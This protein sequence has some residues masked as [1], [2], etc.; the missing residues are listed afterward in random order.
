MEDHKMRMMKDGV[1]F[2]ELEELAAKVNFPLNSDD[3]YIKLFRTAKDLGFWPELDIPKVDWKHGRIPPGPD[4]IR[5]RPNPWYVPETAP[6]KPKKKSPA[7]QQKLDAQAELDRLARLIK[8]LEADP[9]AEQLKEPE[10]EG[11]KNLDK[12]LEDIK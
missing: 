10:L 4:D 2:E 3:D 6:K 5:Y 8:A 12:W 7:M 1:T 9:R 11:I